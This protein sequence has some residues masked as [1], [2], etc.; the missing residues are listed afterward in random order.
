M[1]RANPFDIVPPAGLGRSRI[2]RRFQSFEYADATLDAQDSESPT[3]KHQV[4][5]NRLR[6][7][8]IAFTVLAI[9]L[10]GRAGWLQILQGNAMRTSA[11][12][13]RVRQYSYAAPRGIIYDRLGKALVANVAEF[14]VGIIPADL[15]RDEAEKTRELQK[16]SEIINT[17]VADI[18]KALAQV[19]HTSTD[20]IPVREHVSYEDAMRFR[21]RLHESAAA[22]VEAMPRRQYTVSSSLSP[23]LGYTGKLSDTEWQELRGTQSS[24][25]RFN[26]VIGKTGLEAEYESQLRGQSERTSVEV[27]A[28]RREQKVVAS[29][30]AVPGQNLHTTLDLG[31]QEKLADSLKSMV[32]AVHSTG[33][34]AVAIDPQTGGVLALVTAPTFNSNDFVSGLDAEKYKMLLEDPQRP[35]FFRAIAGEYPSGSTIK[36]VIASAALDQGVISPQTTI[37]STGGIR[38]DKWFFPDWKAG[39]HGSTDV[40]KAIADSVNTFF[41]TIGGGTDTFD[42][43]GIDRMTQYARAFGL[44]APTG[45]D[46]P[47]ERGGFLPSKA[48]K[49]ETKKEP[50]YVGDTYHFAIGQGDLLVTPLQMALSTSAIANRGT[51]YKPH[52]VQAFETADGMKHEQKAEVIRTPVQHQEVLDTVRQ[53]MRQAVTN[54][55]ARRLQ[56]LGTPVAGKTGTAQFGTSNKTH[57]WFIGFAPYENPTIAIAVIVEGGG[58]GHAA[59]LPVAEDGMRYWLTQGKKGQE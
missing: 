17:P 32:R 11:E 54:G 26:D 56:G 27:N 15:S 44:G 57:A 18:E 59:A 48:W 43:L 4:Q 38:I 23:V 41:Y 31:L 19:E 8:A 24:E 49:E 16:I 14:L 35:L 22:R 5:P 12:E 2:L 6:V 50:W 52:I 51:L 1:P 29:E 47:G 39:G 7:A 9:I 20:A 30:A 28:Q 58:E 45:I 34:A 33:G 3:L 13:N 42:G 21:V 40:A 46:L 36:P 53:G 10:F 25:Y 37:M 55:S